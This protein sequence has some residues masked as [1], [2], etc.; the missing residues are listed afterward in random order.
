MIK[1]F[2]VQNYD[3]QNLRIYTKCVS[4]HISISIAISTRQA[5]KPF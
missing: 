2:D 1:D 4:L 5:L 3:L